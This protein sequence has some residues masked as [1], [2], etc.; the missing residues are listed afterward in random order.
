MPSQLLSKKIGPDRW[1]SKLFKGD[2]NLDPNAAGVVEYSQRLPI[3]AARASFVLCH[4]CSP[5]IATR[6]CSPS[7]VLIAGFIPDVIL[8]LSYFYTTSEMTI[9]LSAFWTV[10]YIADIFSSFL[11]FFILRMRNVQGHSGWRWLFLFEGLMTLTIGII[12]FFRMP[13]ISSPHVL[14]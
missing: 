7:S 10:K 6:R 2:P 14:F 1:V 4:P 13:R 3:L 9:R 5:R 11:A 12:S 8:Y